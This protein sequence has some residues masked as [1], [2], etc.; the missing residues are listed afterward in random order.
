MVNTTKT[1]TLQTATLC[2][3]HIKEEPRFRGCKKSAQTFEYADTNYKHVDDEWI[4]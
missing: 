1:Y 4:E 2:F 3:S